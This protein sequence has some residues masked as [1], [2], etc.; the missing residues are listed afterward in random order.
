MTQTQE[1]ITHRVSKLHKWIWGMCM[2]WGQFPKPWQETDKIIECFF[3]LQFIF[4]ILQM[5]QTQE[6]ITNMV[7][8]IY[9]WIWGDVYNRWK[10][11]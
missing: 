1:I 6:I 5:T 10:V 3:F 2:S 9:K 4:Y 7:S 8:N 11:S